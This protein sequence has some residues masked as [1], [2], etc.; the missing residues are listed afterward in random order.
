MLSWANEPWTVRWDGVDRPEGDGTLLAQKYG[1]LPNWKEHFDWMAPYFRHRNYVRNSA[2]GKAQVMV[3]SRDPLPPE[4]SN[5]LRKG[6]RYTPQR[7]MFGVRERREKRS[8]PRK[9]KSKKSL[10]TTPSQK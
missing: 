7:N 5:S 3:V 4:L 1:T 6:L 10:P 8:V 9:E 2:S